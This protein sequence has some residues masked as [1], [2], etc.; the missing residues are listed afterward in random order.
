LILS[1]NISVFTDD[2]VYG[3][4]A[5][6][7]AQKLAQVF[8]AEINT[9]YTDKKTD[10]RAVFLNAADGNTLF[11]VMPVARSRKLS[12]FNLKKA[13]NGIRKSRIPVLTVGDREPEPEHYQQVVL[14]L[15]INCQEKELALWASY[16]PAYFHK[17]C[18][19]IPK[20]NISMHIIYNQ[21][22]DELLRQKVQNNI[23]FVT[24]MFDN[25]EV[26]YELH[27]FTK[28][29]NIHRFGLQFA[30]KT[31]N[32]VLLYL[33]P[34]YYSLIDLIFGPVDNKILGNKEQIPVLCLN[35]REDNFVLCQ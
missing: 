33:M 13:R 34:E 15:D 22:K 4:A 17:N 2:S 26:T 5:E 7:H 29:A 25:L 14:P 24:K 1:Q 31:G 18:P 11:I 3:K 6:A 21:Y 35:A 32:S 27:P 12:F 9:I 8:D 16:F 23:D 28:V 30:Q 20:E 19:N 10:V